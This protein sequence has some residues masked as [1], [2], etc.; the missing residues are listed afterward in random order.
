MTPIITVIGF[1]LAALIGGTWI[2]ETIFNIPGIGALAI[3]AI[4]RRDYPVIQGCLLFS[5]AVYLLVNLL[6]DILYA[7]VNPTIRYQ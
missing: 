7:W 4:L 2:I 3:S 1:S 6:V 5:V